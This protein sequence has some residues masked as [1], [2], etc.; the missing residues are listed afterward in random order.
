MKYN[1]KILSMLLWVTQL[2]LSILLP[3]C[4]F[5][6][7]GTWLRQ[8]YDMGMWIM[9]VLGILGFLTSLS[10]ARSCIRALCKEAREAGKDEQ[11]PSAFNQHD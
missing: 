8:R 1:T 10:T 7:A 11:A 6:L 3:L 2:G 9:V 5:L 4:I